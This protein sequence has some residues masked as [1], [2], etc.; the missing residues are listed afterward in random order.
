MANGRVGLKRTLRLGGGNWKH[1]V[2]Q[3]TRGILDA[4]DGGACVTKGTPG[5]GGG[6]Q[7]RAHAHAPR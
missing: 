6:N 7:R 4:A 1:L 3:I 5:E 2:P